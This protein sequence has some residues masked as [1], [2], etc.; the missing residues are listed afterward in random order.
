MS[1]SCDYEN[2][3]LL[4]GKTQLA[5]VCYEYSL[6][7]PLRGKISTFYTF[8]NYLQIRCQFDLYETKIDSAFNGV[9]Y[10]NESRHLMMSVRQ[11]KQ[12]IY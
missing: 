12:Q 8:L 11:A 3:M 1:A 10:L 4:A 5:I 9:L 7:V 6:V 2:E